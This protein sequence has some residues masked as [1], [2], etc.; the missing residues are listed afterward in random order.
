MGGRYAP[1]PTTMSTIQFVQIQTLGNA[2]DF[3]D[4]TSTRNDSGGMSDCVRA[5]CYGG[6]STDTIEYI[7]LATGGDAVD[8]GNALNSSGYSCN[9]NGHGGL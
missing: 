5:V 9:S 6:D 7:T 8:F 1:S 2:T 3:G 4:L